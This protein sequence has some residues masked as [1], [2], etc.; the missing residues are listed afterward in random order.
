MGRCHH[1]QTAKPFDVSKLYAQLS[2]C[3]VTYQTYFCQLYH[4]LNS[5]LPQVVLFFGL[6]FALDHCPKA[7]LAADPEATAVI[8]Y[9]GHGWRD[10]AGGFYL[11][12]Y[13]VREDRL[14]FTALRAGDFAAQVA[15]LHPPRLLAVLDCC[16]AAGMGLKDV[17]DAAGALPAGYV[18]AAASPSLLLGE[19]G[20]GA[21][22]LGKS[23]AK[24]FE[25]LAQGRGRAVLSSSSGEEKSYVRRDGAMSIFTYHL[26]EALT[27][28][29]QPKEGAGEV[30]VSDLMGHVWRR[31][32]ETAQKEQGK[33]QTPDYRVSGNFPVALLLG[34]KGLSKGMAPPDPL[35]E[36]PAPAPTPAGGLS[37]GGNLYNTG[38]I[39]GRDQHIGGDFVW[40][41]KVGG[42]KVIGDKITTGEIR[43]NVGVAL[44]RGARLTIN[45]TQGVGGGEL[46]RLFKAVY[47]RIKARAPDPNVD[48]PELVETVQKVEQEVSKGEAANPARVERLLHTLALMAGDIFD[49]V[50]ACLASPVAGVGTAIRKVIEKA[51]AERDARR[52]A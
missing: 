15:G 12:P 24:G 20:V 5:S 9:S 2:M 29:A 22:S 14:R 44:G 49:V 33:A 43:D 4:T 7:R 41:D 21:K 46:A 23:G 19:E 10:D 40:G 18:P 8:Y 51:R 36:R 32:P 52:Q 6:T 39:V 13:D 17:G 48:K 25:S 37:V 45:Q 42:D 16:H 28:H 31:V 1:S 47:A 30:L 26:I 35:D 27:G 3:S 50:V 38:N 34:G 11:I